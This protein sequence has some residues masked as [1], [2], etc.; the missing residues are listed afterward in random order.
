[1]TIRHLQIFIA[2][3]E[4]GS[5]SLAARRLFLSQPTVSQVIG[6]M[7]EEYG[8][9][10]F[11]RLA[12][13]LCITDAGL[14]LLDYARHAVS[15][16][17][18]MEDAVGQAAR[19][20]QL[21]VGASIT[22]G[23]CVMTELVR[24]FEEKNPDAEVVVFVDNTSVVEGKVVDSSLD[25]ALVEGRV[26]NERLVVRPVMRDELVLVC[27]PDHP[28]A[29]RK[30]VAV[31]ELD[32][33]PFLLRESGSG[34]REQLENILR[35]NNVHIKPKWVCHSSDA[36]LSAAVGGQGLA[37]LSRL[38]VREAEAQGKLCVLSLEDAKLDRSFQLIY[39]KNKYLSSQIKA[40]LAEVEAAAQMGL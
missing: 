24:R 20:R 34:T 13:R 29:G 14:R 31:R 36:I 12:K 26:G 35:D 16:F 19:R 2:V 27:P 40:F 18:E 7:E 30:K 21:R 6:E 38:L 39:H 17:D 25:F 37:V 4:T 33:Q 1:M 32:G 22:V 23:A 10:L 9:L 15:L 3:A 11:E 28:F 8:V 5:M